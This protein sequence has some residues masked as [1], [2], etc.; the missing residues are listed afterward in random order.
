LVYT[1]L[2]DGMT[3]WR[4]HGHAKRSVTRAHWTP[5]HERA[6]PIDIE[7]AAYVLLAHVHRGEVTSGMPIMRWLA[8]QRNPDGGMA[9]TQVRAQ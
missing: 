9:S 5:P 8:S 4:A 6:T 7:T 2:I 1:I 3:Y